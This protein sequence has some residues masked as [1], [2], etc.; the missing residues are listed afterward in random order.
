[1]SL[2][3]FGLAKRR[4]PELQAGI[5]V[6]QPASLCWAVARG[7]ATLKQPLDAYIENL[8]KTQAWSRLIVK[9]FGEETQRVLGRQ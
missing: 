5:A 8:R 3:D 1:M 6:G 7:N 4:H 9:Y 2:T